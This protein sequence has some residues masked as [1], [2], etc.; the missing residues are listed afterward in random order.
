MRRLSRSF[1][2]G[3]SAGRSIAR[4]AVALRRYY[5]SALA[6][7]LATTDPTI[8]LHVLAGPGRLPRGARPAELDQLLEGPSPEGEP[9]W[10]RRRDDA[11]S[12]SLRV[13]RTRLKFCDLRVDQIRFADRVLIVWGKGAKERRVPVGQPAAASCRP[14]SRCREVVPG[15]DAQNASPTSVAISS[16]PAMCGGF[17]IGGRRRDAPTRPATRSPP[18]SSMVAPTSCGP[19]CW[20]SRRGHHAALHSRQQSAAASAYRSVT[21]A[22]EHRFRRPDLAMHSTR[23][24]NRRTAPRAI[25]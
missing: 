18:T 21:H 10:R 17:W 7:G 25:T 1:L 23:W 12:R 14:R 20:V 2:N 3:A 16:P 4:E 8:G 13:G 15:D 6:E 11:V 9:I 5:G 19:E 24:L 22:D